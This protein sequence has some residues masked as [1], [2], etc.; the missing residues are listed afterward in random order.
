MSIIRFRFFMETVKNRKKSLQEFKKEFKEIDATIIYNSPNYK[1]WI[2][3]Y[4]TRIEVE[5]MFLEIKK[6]YPNALIMKPSLN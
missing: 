3:N 2:G 4:K 6:K 1:V 5:K